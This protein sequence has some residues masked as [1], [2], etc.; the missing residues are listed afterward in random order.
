MNEPKFILIADDYDDA[1]RLLSE[2]V[3]VQTPY[4]T[5][6][7]KDGREALEIAARRKPNVALLDIDMPHIGGI[8][9]AR[10][11]REQ[12]GE[13]RPLLI[14]MTGRADPNE[15]A[16]SGMFDH[17]LKKPLDL[18]ELLQLFEQS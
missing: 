1:A 6:S 15:V 3:E 10:Q 11:L 13:R 2:L 12:F 16:L 9:T 5:V 8:E 7:A 14:A 4:E 17:V 18:A